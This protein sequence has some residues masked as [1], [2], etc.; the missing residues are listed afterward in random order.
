MHST[1]QL[2]PFLAAIL[3]MS[4]V[5]GFAGA[6]GQGPATRTVTLIEL[7]SPPQ[8]KRAMVYRRVR[9]DDR[10]VIGL[11]PG[12]TAADLGTALRVLDVLYAR[13]GETPERDVAASVQ[14]EA[15]PPM[16]RAREKLD[17]SFVQQLRRSRAKHVTGFGSVKAY[18]IKVPKRS[19][20]G[21]TTQ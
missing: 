20:Q 5:P 9:G 17:E 12:A 3:M 10:D 7:P 15:G 13:F 16:P 11:A 1:M 2:R 18:K 6:Q 19:A 14:S 4:T 21:V 8:G